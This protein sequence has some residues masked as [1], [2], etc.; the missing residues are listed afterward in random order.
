METKRT[1]ASRLAS[2]TKQGADRFDPVRFCYITALVRRSVEKHAPVRRRLEHKALQALDD[3][4]VR[5]ENARQEAARHVTRIAKEHPDA[6][7]QLRG[8][9]DQC[10][11]PG[12]GRLAG[13]LDRGR[14]GSMLAKLGD[15][16][17]QAGQRVSENAAPFSL[18]ERLQRQEKEV[19]MSLG[20]S[21][22]GHGA[23]PDM[24]DARLRAFQLFERT[25]AD[26]YADKL[27]TQAVNH[28]PENPG[29]LNTQMLATRCLSAMRKLAPAYLRRWVT[30]ME[31]LFWLEG[32]GRDDNSRTTRGS[33]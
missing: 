2:L 17:A 12:V 29:H 1:A 4:Q 15:Q 9:L 25:W 21:P 33:R 7:K 5:F 19:V 22:A 10:D 28:V 18:D 8:R 20:G 14:G 32:A 6:A 23:P 11:F 26:H 24:P 3:Y 16:I 31:T 13:R 30:Y 27:V